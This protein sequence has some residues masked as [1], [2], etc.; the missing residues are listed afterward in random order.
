M[1]APVPTGADVKKEV[2]QL[3][4]NLLSS[5][6]FLKF[7]ND[8]RRQL[9]SRLTPRQWRSYVEKNGSEPI[10]WYVIQTVNGQEQQVCTWIN[11]RMDHTLFERCFVPLYEDVWRKEVS[12][13]SALRR[14]L[15][16]MYSLNR[17][18]RKQYMK[19]FGKFPGSLIYFLI[20]RIRRSRRKRPLSR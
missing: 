3:V 11:Q 6:R 4:R 18:S 5:I 10:M 20:S 16:A 12:D 14:P 19:N 7:L 9:T 17:I 8:H 1:S 15:P 13:I 2:K